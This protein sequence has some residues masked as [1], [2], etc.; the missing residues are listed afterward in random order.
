[1]ILPLVIVGGAVALLVA[2]RLFAQTDPAVLARMLKAGLI[3]LAVLLGVLMLMRGLALLGLGLFVLPLLLSLPFGRRGRAERTRSGEPTRVETP[4]LIGFVT[5]DGALVDGV[6]RR[7]VFAGRTI[8]SLSQEALFS[9][10]NAVRIDD[11]QGAALLEAYLETG[12]ERPPPPAGGPMTRAQAYDILGL[13]PGAGP[14]EIKSAHHRLIT[15]LHPDQG[16]SS[17]LAALVNQARDTL[18]KS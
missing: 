2:V 14:D 12:G 17:A 18:L 1:M 6:L 11:P 10:L 4:W 5:P 16:G 13:Q 7:G 3:G 9:T 15:S 8:S